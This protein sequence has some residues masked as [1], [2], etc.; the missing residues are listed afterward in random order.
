VHK[1]LELKLINQFTLLYTWKGKNPE[2]KP[3]VLMGHYDVV[4]VNEKEWTVPPFEG[5]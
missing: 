3:V 2:L 4:P 5:K 1:Q